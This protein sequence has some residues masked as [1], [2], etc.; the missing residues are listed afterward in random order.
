MKRLN[1]NLDSQRHDLDGNSYFTA[2]DGTRYMID[3]KNSM[4]LLGLLLEAAGYDDPDGL[5]ESLEE[6]QTKKGNWFNREADSW[7]DQ[8]DWEYENYRENGAA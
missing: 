4:E 2:K 7:G 6:Q 3:R 1:I 5:L 8:S